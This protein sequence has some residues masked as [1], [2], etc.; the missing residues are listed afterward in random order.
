MG[1]SCNTHGRDEK[2]VRTFGP[3]S[4]RKRPLGRP[5]RTWENDIRM[6]LNEIDWECVD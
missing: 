1:G 5:W 6:D 3:K 4:E 2:Y